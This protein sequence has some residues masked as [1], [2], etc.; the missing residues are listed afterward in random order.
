MIHSNAFQT[1]NP[2]G[3]KRYRTGF[4]IDINNTLNQRKILSKQ[5]EWK[6]VKILVRRFRKKYRYYKQ[7]M[8]IEQKISS[9]QFNLENY[10]NYYFDSISKYRIK[11]Y[12]K[13]YAEKL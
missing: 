5:I 6:R 10:L 12:A 1:I 7:L 13:H 8:K 11:K 2:D 9:D 4:I 3:T